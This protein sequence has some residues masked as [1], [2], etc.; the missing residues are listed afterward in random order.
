MPGAAAFESFIE[1]GERFKN[2]AQSFFAGSADAAGAAAGDA[3]RR[4]ADSLREQFE[5]FSQPPWIMAG[6]DVKGSAAV[7]PPALGATREHQLRWQRAA[8]AWRRMD[9]AQRR[10]Q[11]LWSDALRDAAAAFAARRGPPHAAPANA[12]AVQELYDAWIDCLEDAYAR[13]AHG[14]AFCSAFADLANAGSQ[15]RQAI[16]ESIEQASK[17]LDLP[18]RSEVNTLIHRLESLENELHAAPE[19]PRGAG[20][21]PRATR[22]ASRA[23]RKA[24]RAGRKSK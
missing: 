17:F 19:P 15:W 1:A 10:L 5:S 14:E 13:M 7:E 6:G 12:A 22:K 4:F 18:T 9:E 16:Q 21:A 11:R 3:A 24:P 2:A 20:K 23:S 8:E